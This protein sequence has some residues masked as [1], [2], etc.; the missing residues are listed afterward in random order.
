MSRIVCSAGCMLAII[1][2]ACLPVVAE[3]SATNDTDFVKNNISIINEARGEIDNAMKVGDIPGVSVALVDEN[4]ILWAEGFGYTDKTRK[5]PV[6]TDTIFSIQSMSKTI[7][8]TAVMKAVQDGILDLD[9]PINTYLP[10]FTVN[11]IFDEHPEGKITL[12]HLLS[13]TAGFTQEAPIGGN[14]DSNSDTFENHI[15]SISK[16]WLRFPVGENY[17]YSNLGMD[18]AGYIL[19]K[20]SG[21]SFEQYVDENIIK[22]AGMENSSFD[23]VRIRENRNRAVGQSK[24][25]WDV[26]LKILIIPSGGFYSSANDMAKFIQLHLNNGKTNNIQ[27]IDKG[28]LDDMY[29]IPFPVKFQ[30]EGYA[31]GIGKWYR[32]NTYFVNHNGGGFGFSSSMTWYPE[33]KIG[34]ALLTNS[35]DAPENYIWPSELTQSILDKVINKSEIYNTRLNR[36]TKTIITTAP[37]SDSYIETKLINNVM[38]K[39]NALK[40]KPLPGG[41]RWNKYIGQ[42]IEKTY[43]LPFISNLYTVSE[44][45]GALYLNNSILTEVR[46]GLFFTY[47]GEVLDL[48]SRKPAYRNIRLSKLRFGLTLNGIYLAL[49]ALVFVFTIILWLLIGLTRLLRNNLK[50]TA[51]SKS[52]LKA[53]AKILQAVNSGLLL[54]YIVTVVYF[55]LSVNKFNNSTLNLQDYNCFGLIT[56]VSKYASPAVLLLIPILIAFNLLAW[57]NKYWSAVERIYYSC[58]TVFGI[59][60]IAVIYNWNLLLLYI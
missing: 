30:E 53:I 50:N 21:K 49:C 19:Q 44:K 51:D 7:T 55:L 32:N 54:F 58:A 8:A 13:H 18:L 12:R 34:I 25:H 9:K 60:F 14:Y 10:D 26:L 3:V 29:K 16:T 27:L 6:N 39:L 45:D 40:D 28:L 59:L 22:P 17:A 35:A 52:K 15:K 1:F 11:S 33:L 2:C 41:T 4:G 36:L 46:P 5:T 37:I 23:I 38:A 20:V 47:S 24:P 48:A 57:R 31:L 43:G 56:Q 42:Y